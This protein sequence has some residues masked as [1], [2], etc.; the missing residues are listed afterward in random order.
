MDFGTV[1]LLLIPFS[2]FVVYLHEFYA[3]YKARHLP[4]GVSGLQFLFEMPSERVWLMICHFNRKYGAP[5]N[6]D[7]VCCR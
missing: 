5:V 3:R 1:V 6:S 4:P 7:T 2:L